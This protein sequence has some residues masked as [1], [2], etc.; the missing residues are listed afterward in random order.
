MVSVE[1]FLRSLHGWMGVL[2]LPW[3]I[4]AGFTGLYMN[5][6]DLIGGLLPSTDF[7]VEG[8]AAAPGAALQ[9]KDSARAIAVAALPGVVV[10]PKGKDSYLDRDV[11]V[12]ASDQGDVL[13]DAATGHYWLVSRYLRKL[14]TPAGQYVSEQIRWGRVMDSLHGSGWLGRSLGSWPADI[15]AT[16]LMLF[17]FSGLYLFFAPRL[18][19]MRNRRARARLG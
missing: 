1:R 14:Y 8:F 5:H 3:V 10:M 11:F 7:H 12:F 19:R 2:V 17:G 16:A 15:A 13:V 18:R 4:L 6:S 9:D